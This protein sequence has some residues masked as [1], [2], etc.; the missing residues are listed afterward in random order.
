MF[1]PIFVIADRRVLIIMRNI[2]R[3]MAFCSSVGNE[4]DRKGRMLGRGG[5][6]QNTLYT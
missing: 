5:Y 1:D 2:S 3:R 6:A 4:K